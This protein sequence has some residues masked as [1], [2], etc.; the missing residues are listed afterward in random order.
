[1]GDGRL[2]DGDPKSRAGT[3]TVAF[4]AD[5]VPELADHLE[6]FADPKPRKRSEECRYLAHHMRSDDGNRTRMTSLEGVL[7]LAVRAAEL[8]GSLSDGDHD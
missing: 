5:I 3:R 6:R 8:G 4:P 7:H 1:M 2:V